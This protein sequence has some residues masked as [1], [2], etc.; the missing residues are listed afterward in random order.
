MEELK[1]SASLA[2]G[3][4]ITQVTIDH[5]N[6]VLFETE[7]INTV[8][9][10]DR[11]CKVVSKEPGFF[12]L[13]ISSGSACIL[14]WNRSGLNYFASGKISDVVGESINSNFRQKLRDNSLPDRI[15]IQRRISIGDVVAASIVP[16][17]LKEL[18]PNKKIVFATNVGSCRK[19]LQNHP[20]I[21]EVINVGIETPDLLLDNAYEKDIGFHTDHMMAMYLRQAGL[22]EVNFLPRLGVTE[23]ERRWALSY[24]SKFP[25]PW[26]ICGLRSAHGKERTPADKTWEDLKNYVKEGTYFGCGGPTEKP[27]SWMVDLVDKTTIRQLMALI[28]KCDLVVTADSSPLHIAQAF[29]KPIVVLG[30]AVN[31]DLRLA[32]QADWAEVKAGLDCQ[33]CS[34]ECYINK[35]EP[36]CSYINPEHI[37]EEIEHKLYKDKK[38]TA[39]IPLYHPDQDNITKCI[40]AIKD[41]VDEIIIGLDGKSE[42]PLP[43]LPVRC[44]VIQSDKRL[45]YSKMINLLARHA[46]NPILL[47]L[48]DDVYLQNNIIKPHTQLIST[49]V[50]LIGGE[51]RY[52]NNLIQHGGMIWNKEQQAYEHVSRNEEEPSIKKKTFMDSVTFAAVLLDKKTFYE[53]GGF[54][55]GFDCYWEDTD[56]CTRI[57]KAK[58]KILYSPEFKGIHD[59]SSS[60]KKLQRRHEIWEEGKARYLNKHEDFH[61]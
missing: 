26:V 23:E 24:L 53:L 8:L 12:T 2:V 5:T 36:P 7:E 59:E 35:D 4:D 48:N 61:V 15:V 22:E 40:S 37:A 45:G 49:A 21:D 43:V 13:E 11:K 46:S 10:E 30:M 32:N 19:V 33:Y 38:V 31:P 44:R 42:Y 27:I 25:K 60:T 17:K 9:S 39:L 50:P 6:V 1:I 56:L 29:R 54:D 55:E 28:A 20:D 51:F 57:L 34:R 58:K 18:Y 16:T 41:Q 52:Q 3:E 14:N 47:L